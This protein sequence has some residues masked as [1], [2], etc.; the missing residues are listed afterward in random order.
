VQGDGNTLPQTTITQQAADWLATLVKPV[1]YV[2]AAVG[3]VLIVS[4]CIFLIAA[5]KRRNLLHN[6]G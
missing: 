4:G 3:T 2:V 6:N 1:G 5:Y